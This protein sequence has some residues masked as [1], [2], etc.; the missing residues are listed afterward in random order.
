M[1]EDTGHAG[2]FM[3][4][5]P[6]A[7]PAAMIDDWKNELVAMTAPDALIADM[8]L[9]WK[10]PRRLSAQRALALGDNLRAEL[11]MHDTLVGRGEVVLAGESL[12][13]VR[14]EGVVTAETH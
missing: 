4:G 12:I 5:R 7:I 11:W 9:K 2:S 3:L 13:D 10:S 1:V 14:M 8:V 6:R